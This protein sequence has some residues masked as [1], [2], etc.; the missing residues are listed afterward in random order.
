MQCDT[1]AQSPGIFDNNS[2]V[3][4]ATHAGS[5][6]FSQSSNEYQITG[7]G[8]NIWGEKDAF[9]FLWK[10]DSGDLNLTTKIRW[11]GDGKN[12]HRKAGWMIRQSLTP[13]SPYV[14]AVIHGDGLT[15]LQFRKTKGGP[16]EEIQSQIPS[17]AFLRLE[18]H[19]EVFSLYICEDGKAFQPVGSVCVALEDPVYVGLAVC[20]HDDTTTETAI[21]SQ[22][23]MKSL[24]IHKMEDRI[25]ESSLETISVETGQ[26]RGQ[27]RQAY[28][29]KK[30]VAYIAGLGYDH[31]RLPIDEEQMWDESGKKENEA[32]TLL[33]NAIK[34]SDGQHLKVVVDLHILRSHHFNA[35][36]KD[37]CQR[38]PAKQD[39]NGIQTFAIIWKNTILPGR[40]GTIREASG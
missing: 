21:F 33:N 16:T 39:C 35:E 4:L 1:S 13:D 3:G 37:V 30:D 15:S 12:A 38:S 22:V 8:E 14:D 5:V 34:W 27:D 18:R 2:D 36:D 17:P 25:I 23:D 24:G 40:I 31:I 10:K 26:R 20:S 28:F 9:Q 29:T 19:G 11:I 32:F 7:G 6:R